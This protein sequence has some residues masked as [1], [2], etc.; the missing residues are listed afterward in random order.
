MLTTVPP[1]PSLQRVDEIAKRVRALADE[2]GPKKERELARDAKLT[3]VHVNKI[4]TRGGKNTSATTLAKIAQAGGVTLDWLVTGEG[5]RVRDV[6]RTPREIATAV[7]LGSDNELARR[8]GQRV[9]IT[10][11]K[12][13]ESWDVVMWLRTLVHEF[14]RANANPTAYDAETA[15]ELERHR[16]HRA[17]HPMPTNPKRGA[18]R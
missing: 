2:R 13:T 4:L 15:A 10:D 6:G 9:A 3:P 7:F 1:P 17:P 16:A 5:P 14:D 11:F 12:G 8:V 18:N